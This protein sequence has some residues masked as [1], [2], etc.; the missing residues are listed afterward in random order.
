MQKLNLLIT[1]NITGQEFYDTENFQYPDPPNLPWGNVGNF[2][3]GIWTSIGPYNG[4]FNMTR[5]LIHLRRNLDGL[6]SFLILIN[7]YE[8][9]FLFN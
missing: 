1:N 7:Y 2:S 6:F 3:N 8:E 5:D 4:W 9:Y